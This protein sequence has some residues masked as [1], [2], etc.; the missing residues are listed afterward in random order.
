MEKI[1]KA[2]LSLSRML[3]WVRASESR[4]SIIFSI[5]TAMIGVVIVLLKTADSV[6]CW[7]L[8]LGIVTLA[9]LLTTVAISAI[10]ILPETEGPGSFIYFGAIAKKQADQYTEEF[11]A[12][13]DEEYLDDLLA[14]CHRNAEIANKKYKWVQRSMGCLFLSIVPWLLSIY[15]LYSH[16]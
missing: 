7:G 2:E 13:S 5:S 1:E 14:Q 12:L 8:G 9:L 15:L 6:D 11:K 10:A 3:E 4:I 16:S